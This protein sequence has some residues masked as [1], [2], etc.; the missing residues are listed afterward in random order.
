MYTI[1]VITIISIVA[2]NI[3]VDA[4]AEHRVCVHVVETGYHQRVQST[5]PIS[6]FREQK[7]DK[8]EK[9]CMEGVH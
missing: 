9:A 8:Y 5:T 4:H 7:A 6:D 3:A 2:I 1:A